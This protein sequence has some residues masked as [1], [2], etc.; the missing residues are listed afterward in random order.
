MWCRTSQKICKASKF[1]SPDFLLLQ[2]MKRKDLQTA[3]FVMLSM[4]WANVNESF[5][6][7]LSNFSE[8]TMGKLEPSSW[9]AIELCWH[10][11]KAISTTW[12]LWDWV[13]GVTCE[14]NSRGSVVQSAG[15]L[16]AA[17][18]SREWCRSHTFPSDNLVVDNLCYHFELKSIG[19]KTQLCGTDACKCSVRFCTINKSF[20]TVILREVSNDM[21]AFCAAL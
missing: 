18:P 1:V 16:N 17:S 14:P 7:K 2:S 3:F 6:V 19:L 21:K 12:L 5:C 11:K 15:Y 8:F 9:Y 20:Y 10:F 4:C 13:W